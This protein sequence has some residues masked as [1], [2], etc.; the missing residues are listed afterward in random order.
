MNDVMKQGTKTIVNEHSVVLGEMMR[1]KVIRMSEQIKPDQTNFE[2]DV[3]NCFLKS[4]VFVHQSTL[5]SPSLS[6]QIINPPLPLRPLPNT[7]L[8]AIHPHS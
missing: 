7:P 6:R 5:L 2:G 8:S 1:E 3:D 4:H